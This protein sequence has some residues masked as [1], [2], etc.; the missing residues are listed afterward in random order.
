VAVRVPCGSNQAS[1]SI[2]PPVPA[3]RGGAMGGTL[4][5]TPL[6]IGA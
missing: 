6:E 3:N 4:S 1:A 5:Y 2:G